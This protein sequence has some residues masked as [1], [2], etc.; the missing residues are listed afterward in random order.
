MYPEFKF[1]DK[2]M[3]K[4]EKRVGLAIALRL[5]RKLVLEIDEEI[6]NLN[7]EKIYHQVSIKEA[8]KVMNVSTS[9][10]REMI[11]RDILKS[12]QIGRRKFVLIKIDS[13]LIDIIS[14][15]AIRD[16]LFPWDDE[17]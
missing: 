7:D 8:S 13:N 17:R 12:I 16:L 11:D 14:E 9:I 5:L 10:I 15:K 1:K 4:Q 6:D 2:I 3:K